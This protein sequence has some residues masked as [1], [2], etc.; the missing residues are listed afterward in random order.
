MQL[1]LALLQNESEAVAVKGEVLLTFAACTTPD[2]ANPVVANHGLLAAVVRLL[3]EC[4]DDTLVKVVVDFLG[5]LSDQHAKLCAAHPDI[6]RT[7]IGAVADRRNGG[8]LYS[9]IPLLGKL[10]SEGDAA[11]TAIENT[12]VERITLERIADASSGVLDPD[13]ASALEAVTRYQ[14]QRLQLWDLNANPALTIEVLNSGTPFEQELVLKALC[15]SPAAVRVDFLTL[16][17]GANTLVQLHDESDSKP[18]QVLSRLIAEFA[19][20]VGGPVCRVKIVDPQL[21]VSLTPSD[22][23]P[24]LLSPMFLEAYAE[25]DGYLSQQFSEVIARLRDGSDDTKL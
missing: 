5:S 21:Q 8:V 19:F 22:E 10:A 3:D 4:S 9:A 23:A 18:V 17:G 6:P 12:I 16:H 2:G 7:L 15:V 1:L 24:Q 13:N 25:A 11:A 20:D 14:W